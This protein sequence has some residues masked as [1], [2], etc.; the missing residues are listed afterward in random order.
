M[1]DTEKPEVVAI[2]TPPAL[3]REQTLLA[4]AHGCH[5][6]CEKPLT[7]SL[8]ETD[9]IIRAA[10]AAGRHVVVNTQFPCM[11][12]HTAAKAQIGTPDFGRLQFLHAWQAFRTSAT[13]EVGWRGS[14]QRRVCLEFGIHVFELVRFFFD[15]TPSR[16]YC[17]MPAT[18]N[19]VESVD[20]IS[21][22]FADGRAA[23]VVLDRVS[24]APDRYL[25]MTLDG[26]RATIQ[27]S[28]G[29]ELR[30]E[31]GLQ[32]RE[33]RPFWGLHIVKGGK[34]VRYNGT[35]ATVLATDGMNP[36]AAA[37]A[38]HFSRFLD[39]IAAGR[40]PPGTAADHRDTLGLALAAYTSA[41]SRQPVELASYLR[42]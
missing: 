26:E 22:E 4:L 13:T 19:G 30:F 41:E 1:I 12:I 20:I 42:A 3:H 23:S 9:E 33:R 35:R 38:V 40:T 36:F 17:H 11:R 15:A 7:E 32:T 37:T 16:I 28:I 5:V 2:C 29:G 21:L 31:V 14:M 6:F 39:A 8:T 18:A 25:D 10:T 34:A 24:Q 27:T